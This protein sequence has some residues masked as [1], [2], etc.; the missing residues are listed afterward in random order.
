MPRSLFF[1]TPRKDF[2]FRHSTGPLNTA[3]HRGLFVAHGFRSATD[4]VG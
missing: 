2:L 4:L 3:L 1:R